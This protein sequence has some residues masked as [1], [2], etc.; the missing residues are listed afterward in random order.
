[1]ATTSFSN[2]TD[3]NGAIQICEFQC[4][5]GDAGISGDAT[6][7]K[8]FTTLI[9][10]ANSE[11]WHE[12]FM[13]NSGWKYD[14]SNN[15]D[16]P[17]GTQSLTNGVSKYA[18]PTTALAV[19]RVEVMDSSG[20]FSLLTPVSQD[21]IKDGIDTIVSP[22]GIPMHYRLIGSTVELFPAPATGSVTLTGG[23]K[24]YFKR[25]SSSFTSTDTT[26]TFG[27][28]SEYHD[29]PPRKASISW[30][31]INKPTF[32]GLPLLI[33]KDV[34]RMNSLRSFESKKFPAY[35]KKLTAVFTSGR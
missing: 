18:L 9:N 3:K 16:L 27:F 10:I 32:A 24:V 14:D 1:M 8:L 19:E 25:G 6:R 20:R 15:A 29:I 7:L 13:A 33:Q 4:G 31:S 17:Q 21:D 22:S 35:T 26:K 11:T 5:L 12:I 23:L 28:A 30:L 34:E 2:T